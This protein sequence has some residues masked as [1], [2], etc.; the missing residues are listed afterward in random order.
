MKE[1]KAEGQGKHKDFF[2]KEGNLVY[3]TGMSRVVTVMVTTG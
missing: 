1:I 2:L 3:V